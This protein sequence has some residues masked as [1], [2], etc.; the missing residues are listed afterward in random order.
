[1]MKYTIRFKQ[2]LGTALIFAMMVITTVPIHADIKTISTDR[3]MMEAFQGGGYL[4]IS[5]HKYVDYVSTMLNGNTTR[6]YMTATTLEHLTGKTVY[7]VGR[8]GGEG[9]SQIRSDYYMLG[10]RNITLTTFTTH[11]AISTNAHSVMITRNH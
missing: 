1:M 6:L 5:G 8:F 9:R 2:I 11:E 7:T 3:G 10:Y 4:E